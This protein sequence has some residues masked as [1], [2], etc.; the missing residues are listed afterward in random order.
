MKQGS[1]DAG[2]VAQ[3]VRYL[4]ALYKAA[5]YYQLVLVIWEQVV[6]NGGQLLPGLTHTKEAHVA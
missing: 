5:K 4:V 6:G 1:F 3:I 2:C